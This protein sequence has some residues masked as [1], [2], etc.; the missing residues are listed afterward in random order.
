M[1]V[2]GHGRFFPVRLLAIAPSLPPGWRKV[3]AWSTGR[4][5][6]WPRLG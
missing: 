6:V 5:A 1:A 2:G 3:R 4:E